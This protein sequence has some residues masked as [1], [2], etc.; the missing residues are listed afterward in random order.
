MDRDAAVCVV[1]AVVVLT[2]D[3]RFKR[4]C[5]CLVAIALSLHFRLPSILYSPTSSRPIPSSSSTGEGKTISKDKGTAPSSTKVS[6]PK[7]EDDVATGV[8]VSRKASAQSEPQK[9]DGSAQGSAPVLAKYKNPSEAISLRQMTLG[10]QVHMSATQTSALLTKVR[11]D[12][13][14]A[15]SP[16]PYMLPKRDGSVV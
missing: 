9:M 6:I 1:T 5:V 4:M 14:T 8:V 7:G 2:C 3:T 10:K 15:Q 16:D 13:D 11:T 12:Y